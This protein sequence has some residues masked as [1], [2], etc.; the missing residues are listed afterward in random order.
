MRRLTETHRPHSK[1]DLLVGRSVVIGREVNDGS[2]V[3]ALAGD[4]ENGGTALWTRL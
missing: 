1:A 3:E 4:G 2:L